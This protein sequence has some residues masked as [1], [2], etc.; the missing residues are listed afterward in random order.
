[1]AAA[2]TPVFVA[3]IGH[4]VSVT[5]SRVD[6]PPLLSVENV[7]WWNRVWHIDEF[8]LPVTVGTH[9]DEIYVQTSAWCHITW[10]LMFVFRAS[11]ATI[12]ST[13]DANKSRQCVGVDDETAN[14]IMSS[15]ASLGTIIRLLPLNP[16]QMP[17]ISCADTHVISWLEK[18]GAMAVDKSSIPPM[19]MHLPFP[20]GPG[21]P[22]VRMCVCTSTADDI[23]STPFTQCIKN[24]PNAYRMALIRA[25]TLLLR[26]LL[27]TSTHQLSKKRRRR[28]LR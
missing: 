6:L 2:S 11:A 14:P 25:E 7:E 19:H 27:T 26:S 1:M 15:S 17:S 10:F 22:R 18:I 16:Q 28:R 8:V 3:N 13:N 20:T 24:S 12:A 23:P 4:R 21:A 9:G 5:L